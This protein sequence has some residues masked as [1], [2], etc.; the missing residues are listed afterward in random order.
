MATTQ[1]V[2]TNDFSPRNTLLG[3]LHLPIIPR[4]SFIATFVITSIHL[5]PD[6]LSPC[7]SHFQNST[8]FA[9]TADKFR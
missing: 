4:H 1:V 9:Q 7:G 6:K 8:S 3:Q 5:N 2:D